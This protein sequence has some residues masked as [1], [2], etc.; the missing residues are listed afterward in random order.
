MWN[1]KAEA[2]RAKLDNGKPAIVMA[3][4]DP[5]AAKLATGASILLMS[6]HLELMHAM[7]A[8]QGG[9]AIADRSIVAYWTA[10]RRV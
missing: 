7:T 10:T 4:H 9:P 6:M 2:L 1:A 8:V 3:A 5:R